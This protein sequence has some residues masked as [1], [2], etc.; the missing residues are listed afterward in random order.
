MEGICFEVKPRG[1]PVRSSKPL[2]DGSGDED[3]EEEEIQYRLKLVGSLAVHPQTSMA[4][5]PW[6]VAEIRRPRL[7]ERS[8]STNVSRAQ[9]VEMRD[10]PVVLQISCS[11]VRCV[12]GVVRVGDQWD[13]LQHTV[14]FQQRPHRV[15]KLIHNSREPS[16]FGC[17]LRDDTSATCYV[18]RCQDE[19]R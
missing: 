3:E 7:K 15:T 13:P 14:L 11:R 19:H 8:F 6:V 10:C 18:F 12:L 1:D 5:L 4:M 17:L 2:Q 9:A 16:Y